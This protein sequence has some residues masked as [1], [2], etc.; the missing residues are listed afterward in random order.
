LAYSLLTA[1][2][3]IHARNHRV[4]ALDVYM[5]RLQLFYARTHA[6][7]FALLGCTVQTVASGLAHPLAFGSFSQLLRKRRKMQVN[8]GVP[9]D[10]LVSARWRKSQASNPSGSCVEV[11]ELGGDGIAVRNSRHPSGPALI[12]TRAEIDAF[13][14]GVKNGEF[15]DLGLSG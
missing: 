8:N 14:I 12:Y 11:A 7:A 13:L 15:D 5:L 9:A 1:A 10:Q 2:F 4:H 3:R 6:S